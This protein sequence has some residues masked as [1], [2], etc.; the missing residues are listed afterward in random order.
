MKILF[1]SLSLLLATVLTGCSST[2]APPAWQSSASSSL[3]SFSSAY[4]SGNTRVADLE[5]ARARTELAATGRADLVAQAELIRCAARVASL[6]I[7]P[8]TGFQAIADDVGPAERTYAAYIAG[9]WQDV[10]PALLPAH[11]RAVVNGPGA[12]KTILGDIEDPFSRLV[13]AGALLQYGR[14]TPADMEIATETASSQG[15]R[16]PLLAWLGVQAQRA[17]QAGALDAYAR[18]QRRIELVSGKPK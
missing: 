10:D 15:W 14:L 11:H 17:Q 7:G 9:R 5:F 4:L 18:I 12:G 2:P 1:S 6:E 8:C 16:R 3:Q 13:A